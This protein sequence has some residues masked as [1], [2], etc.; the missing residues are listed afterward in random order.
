MSIDFSFWR[1]P[2]LRPI[3][4]G[5]VFLLRAGVE[6]EEVAPIPADSI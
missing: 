4:R 3:T 5:L 6:V 2:H 1:V